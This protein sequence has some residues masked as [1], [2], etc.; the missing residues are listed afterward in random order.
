MLIYPATDFSPEHARSLLGV[1]DQKTLEQLST[2]TQVTDRTPP[3]FIWHNLTDELL[4]H[5]HALRFAHACYDHDVLC[6]L[7]ILGYGGHGFGTKEQDPK[8]KIWRDICANWLRHLGFVESH[9]KEIE[10]D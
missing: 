7:H 9:E 2:W 4:S 5:A 10:D 8:I 6:E 1:S 3:T